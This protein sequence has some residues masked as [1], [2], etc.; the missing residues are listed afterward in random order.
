MLLSSAGPN[1]LGDVTSVSFTLTAACAHHPFS[2]ELL[3]DL[4]VSLRPGLFSA[5]C[6]EGNGGA[7]LPGSW[8]RSQE[9]K[10]MAQHLAHVNYLFVRTRKEN[11]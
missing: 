7:H 6:S 2:P 8:S 3:H 11:S 10:H 9:L 4:R 5:V 1:F